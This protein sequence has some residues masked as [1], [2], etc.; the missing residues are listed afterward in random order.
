M[1]KQGATLIVG[2]CL[3]LTTIYWGQPWLNEVEHVRT[4]KTVTSVRDASY[5]KCEVERTDLVGGASSVQETLYRC[6]GHNA[7]FI[8]ST[9]L[10]YWV[11]RAPK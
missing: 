8:R 3:G 9:E 11:Y 7:F 4:T 2:F 10:S 5:K 1:I 6:G